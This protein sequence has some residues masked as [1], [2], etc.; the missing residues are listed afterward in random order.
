MQDDASKGDAMA[1]LVLCDGE[2][3]ALESTCG[4]AMAMRAMC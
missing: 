2:A 1:M 4:D 3:M